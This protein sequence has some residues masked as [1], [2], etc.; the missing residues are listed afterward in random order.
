MLD[1]FASAVLNNLFA[2][3]F[4]CR[5]ARWAYERYDFDAILSLEGFRMCGS[6]HDKYSRAEVR[7]F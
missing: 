1:F 7:D 3:G 5:S 2:T 6:S 4:E